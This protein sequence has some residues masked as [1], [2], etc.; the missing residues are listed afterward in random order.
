[1]TVREVPDKQKKEKKYPSLREEGGSEI[2]QTSHSDLDTKKI[3]E[4]AIK[5]STSKYLGDNGW[6]IYLH[7]LLKQSDKLQH[8][9]DQ[10]QLLLGTASARVPGTAEV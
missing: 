4:Y 7:V 6:C 8:S 10:S 1:M 2:L 5:E 9:S 3:M